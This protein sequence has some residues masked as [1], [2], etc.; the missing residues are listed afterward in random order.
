LNF[1][2]K[3]SPHTSTYSFL[4]SP[5]TYYLNHF[6]FTSPDSI[7]TDIPPRIRKLHNHFCIPSP[8]QYYFFFTF[9]V[10]FVKS[11][12]CGP[13]NLSAIRIKI[14]SKASFFQFSLPHS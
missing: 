14:F 9:L 8:F 12:K 1:I 3:N 5:C 10:C 4:V 7:Y 13:T 11:D 6:Y 2:W